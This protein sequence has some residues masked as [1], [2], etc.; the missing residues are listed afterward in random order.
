MSVSILFV[1]LGNICRSPLAEGAFRAEAARLGLDVE[2]DSAGTGGWH[3]SEP[4]DR[5]AIAAA[6]RGGVDISGQRARK[7]TSADFDRFDHIVALDEDNLADLE[8][9][10]PNG[11]RAHLSLLLDHVPGREGQGVAD[12]YYGGDRDF[13]ATWRDVTETARALAHKLT[14]EHMA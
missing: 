8:R 6:K 11:S 7:V 1:C 4:P 14:K 5:R 12:P 10:Q 2:P 9:L 13:D 3:Q